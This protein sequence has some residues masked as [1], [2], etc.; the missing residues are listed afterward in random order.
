MNF[1]TLDELVAI[2]R[3]GSRFY[4]ELYA[5]LPERGFTLADLPVARFER[6]MAAVHEDHRALV[7]SDRAYGVCYTTSG[8]TGRP[9]ATIFGRDE[10]RTAHEILSLMHW[11]SGALRDGDIVCNLSEPGSASFMAIHRVVDAFPGRCS[12]IPIGC[13]VGFAA[14]ARV[15]EQFQASVV[16]GMS[17]TILGF[18]DWLL[19]NRGPNPG[20]RSLLGGGE[21]FYGAQVDLLRQAFPSATYCAFMYGAAEAGLIGYGEPSLPHDQVRVLDSVCQ[22]E[23]IRPDT[24]VP[25]TTPG[26]VG[27]TVVTHFLRVAAPALRLETG[28]LAMWHD[29]P[30][31]PNPRISLRGRLFPFALDVGGRRLCEDD[32]LRLLSAIELRLPLL[33]LQLAVL[34]TPSSPRFELRIAFAAADRSRWEGLVREAWNQCCPDLATLPSERRVGELTIREVPLSAFEDASRRKSRLIVDL[35]TE[36]REA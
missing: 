11:K 14:V 4:A 10:W 12:E 18:A 22:L 24:H 31:T 2:A 34:G 1:H 32:V 20:V 27:R 6:V 5:G 30:D 29:A 26:E 17:P 36:E 15:C 8:T 7:A 21:R 9:K 33:K 28:D 3:R 19:R 35:R 23:I 16:A 25:I 13:D